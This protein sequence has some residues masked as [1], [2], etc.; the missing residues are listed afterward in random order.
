MS[1]DNSDAVYESELKYAWKLYYEGVDE[2]GSRRK[3]KLQDARNVLM[4]IPSGYS[5]RDDLMR[6][7]EDML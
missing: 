1:Y 4:N 2:E 5:N 6:Y 7:I 3:R